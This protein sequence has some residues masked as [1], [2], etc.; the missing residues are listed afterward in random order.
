MRVYI[1]WSRSECK[2]ADTQYVF[3]GWHREGH[4]ALKTLHCC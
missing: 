2:T 4:L 1:K 3:A